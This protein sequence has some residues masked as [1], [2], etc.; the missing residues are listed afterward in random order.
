MFG[1]QNI[2]GFTIALQIDLKKQNRMK[3][4]TKIEI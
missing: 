2:A 1:R 3:G 4:E